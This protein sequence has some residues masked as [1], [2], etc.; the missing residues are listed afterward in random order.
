[1]KKYI[2]KDKLQEYTTKLTN[3]YKSVFATK[4]EVG[5][6]LVA[7]TVAEMTDQSKVYVYAGS[8]SGYTSGNWYYYNGSAWV[9][10]GVYNSQGFVLD[11]TLTDA[12]KPAQAKA[13][14]DEVSSLK[15]AFSSGNNLLPLADKAS[16]TWHGV[17][18]SV[19]NG[20]ITLS[21]TNSSTLTRIKI[22]NG[23]VESSSYG[24]G[25]GSESLP[26]FKQGATYSLHNIII[27]GTLPSTVGVSLRNSSNGVIISGSQ[28]EKTI[29]EAACYAMLYIPANTTVNVTF[30]PVFIEGW[31]NSSVYLKSLSDDV[32]VNGISNYATP[33]MTADYI[34]DSN[35]K[36]A[37]KF[38]TTYSA[39]GKKTPLLV[40]CHGLSATVDESTWGVTAQKNLINNFVNDGYAVLDVQQVTTEDWCNPVLIKRYKTAIRAAIEKYNIEPSVVYGASMGSLI[41]L[42]IV[43]FYAFKAVAIG[44][45]RL[46]FAA[47]YADLT[48]ENKAIVDAN[49]GFTNGYDANIA[50]GWSRTAIAAIDA[51]G[52]KLNQNHF[53]PTFFVKGDADEKTAT[54][55]TAR[56]N[57][58]KRG[59]TIC[60]MNTYAG[61]HTAAWALTAGTSYNDVKAWFEQWR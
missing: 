56:V 57:E 22:S 51:D 42:T 25:W 39:K 12:T 40:Y 49:L 16:G 33:D 7:S 44:G 23:Y 9:S 37:I 24:S 52:Q 60:Q 41:A 30:I 54:E 48:T 55:S 50:A 13:V 17:T 18:W 28:P 45:L 35:L 61:D 53:P 46:D 15:S 4:S 6:P 20:A 31:T 26:Q 38:P 19:N 43:Q 2:D 29:S 8:E 14:G 5:S 11:D 47:S 34:W 32:Y 1:M 36:Y 27:S 3:K 59:G 10:G 21:G 58:I